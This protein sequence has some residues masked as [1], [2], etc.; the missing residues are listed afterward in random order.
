MPSGL[1]A[2]VDSVRPPYNKRDGWGQL[3]FGSHG[4]GWIV[5]P[6]GVAVHNALTCLRE[7]EKRGFAPQGMVPAS[8]GHGIMLF[9]HHFTLFC[10][11]FLN[12]GEVWVTFTAPT[13]GRLDVLAEETG[14]PCY[15]A[16]REILKPL[17][18]RGI[19]EPMP[20]RT[21]QLVSWCVSREDEEIRRVVRLIRDVRLRRIG[22]PQ[23]IKGIAPQ[24]FAEGG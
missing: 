7:C 3:L 22:L 15:A 23:F 21:E 6:T 9:F 16:L 11:E 8:L 20:N 1:F 4:D 14:N 10:M 12:S 24:F 13:P 17:L 5:P 18:E 19:V 2:R